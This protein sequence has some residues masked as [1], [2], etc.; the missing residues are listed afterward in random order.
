[1]LNGQA[2]SRDRLRS[3]KSGHLIPVT[4]MLTVGQRGFYYFCPDAW[5]SLP[6]ELTAANNSRPLWAF[7][8]QLKT[9]VSLRLT[10]QRICDIL[11][12]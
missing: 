5:N 8:K 12:V 9:F 2:V 4:R 3:A 7:K 11:V 1:M 10:M 6:P